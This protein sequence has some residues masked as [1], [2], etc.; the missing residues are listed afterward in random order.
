M[1]NK[2]TQA[3]KEVADIISFVGLDLDGMMAEWV[4]TGDTVASPVIMEQ[5]PEA[6]KLEICGGQNVFDVFVPANQKV[7]VSMMGPYD[8]TINTI[9]REEVA[10]YAE[11]SKD[12]DTAIADF[13][14]G[15]ANV[16][17]VQVD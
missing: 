15:V 7:D 5:N 13:K 4:K 10:A 11:G 6:G 3:K 2:D 12:L 17:D 1:A 14:S 9:F 8:E 16:I